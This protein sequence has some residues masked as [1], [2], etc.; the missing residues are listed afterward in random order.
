MLRPEKIQG[1]EN[2]TSV[3]TMQRSK[4]PTRSEVFWT[5]FMPYLEENK[6]VKI[7]THI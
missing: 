1:F 4:K 5:K 6:I 2:M 3:I 7:Y